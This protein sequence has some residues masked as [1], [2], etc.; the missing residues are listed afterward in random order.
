MKTPLVNQHKKSEQ[1]KGTFTHTVTRSDKV[2]GDNSF[3]TRASNF[4]R[5]ERQRPLVTRCDR[6]QR[7]D[8]VEKS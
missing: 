1:T 4:R 7:H 8:R 6:V 3:L 2:T 5:H